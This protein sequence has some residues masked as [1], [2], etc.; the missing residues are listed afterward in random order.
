MICSPREAAIGSGSAFAATRFP[1]LLGA[2]RKTAPRCRA[3][4]AGNGSIIAGHPSSSDCHP[5][6]TPPH[7]VGREQRQ[8]QDATGTAAVWLV[9]RGHPGDRGVAAI[10]STPFYRF[11]QASASTTAGSARV[12]LGATAGSPCGVAA[13]APWLPPD[14]L[15]PPHSGAGRCAEPIPARGRDAW[16]GDASAVGK[17]A[18]AGR[19]RRR[20]HTGTPSG[21][22][23]KACRARSRHWPP[24][25]CQT[26]MT[27]TR[28]EP[29]L[30]SLSVSVE[31]TWRTIALSPATATLWSAWVA[32]L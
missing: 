23:L 28:A 6:R 5:C 27:P 32:D 15:R 22:I 31:K 13:V 25:F 18:P 1:V 21:Q 7:D 24:C 12:R 9:R 8:L 11:A 14:G 20:R 3:H 29:G 17:A 16:R 4:T 26:C 30:P 19:A 10:P 2:P